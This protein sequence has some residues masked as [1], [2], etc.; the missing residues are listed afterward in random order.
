MIRLLVIFIA[1]LS[2][3]GCSPDLSSLDN[4]QTWPIPRNEDTLAAYNRSL[5]NWCV[6]MKDGNITAMKKDMIT[7]DTLPFTINEREIDRLGISSERLFIK[8]EDG[9]LVEFNRG[10]WGADLYWFSQDG[11][12]KYKISGDNITQFFSYNKNIYAV[13]GFTGSIYEGNIFQIKKVK[14]TWISTNY[15]T[16]S[17]P[18][19][20]AGFD[21]KGNLIVITLNSLL[22]ITPKLE[23]TTLIKDGFWKTYLNPNSLVIKDNIVYIGMLVGIFKYNLATN[24]QE[25]MMPK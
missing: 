6:I 9:Y 16:L 23:I 7:K 22:S 8:V 1:A 5:E 24:K 15:I 18:C 17:A 25:W 20:C 10:E 11:K 3:N 21:T 13:G 19:K 14:N 2:I 4:W 12:N